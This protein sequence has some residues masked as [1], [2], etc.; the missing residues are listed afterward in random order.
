MFAKIAL[1]ENVKTFVVHMF[2]LSLESIYPDREALISSLLTEKVIILD[3]Y[4]NFA[5]VFF[6]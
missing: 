3:K 1:D 2:S 6:K 5:N 4:S